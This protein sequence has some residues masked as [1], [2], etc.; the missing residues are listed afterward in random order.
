M[1]SADDALAARVDAV[2]RAVSES[3]VTDPLN[4]DGISPDQSDGTAHLSS[5]PDLHTIDMP[6]VIEGNSSNSNSTIPEDTSS[7]P[8]TANNISSSSLGEQT[9]TVTTTTTSQIRM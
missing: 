1:D 9:S 8:D 3:T 4:L 5:V 6:E 2:E 7:P